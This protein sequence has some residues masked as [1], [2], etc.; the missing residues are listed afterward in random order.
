MQSQQQQQEIPSTNMTDSELLKDGD[1]YNGENGLI[2]NPFNSENQE[3][4]TN[5]IQNI[6]KRYG[7]D[8][9]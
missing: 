6:L 1:I 3:I 8:T 4:T 2:F 7:I 9:C 5:D